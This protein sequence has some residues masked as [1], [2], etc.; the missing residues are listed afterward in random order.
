MD[1]P[2]EPQK[3]LLQQPTDPEPTVEA[4]ITFTESTK[5]KNAGQL[6]F[7]FSQLA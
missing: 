2:A 5:K 6:M 4:T 7:D 1:S 3:T